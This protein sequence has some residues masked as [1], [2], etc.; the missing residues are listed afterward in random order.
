M[1]KRVLIALACAIA[2][3]VPLTVFAA[4]SNTDTA[5]AV[6]GFFGVDAS[7]LTDQQK[8]DVAEY[9]QKMADLQKE[10]IN[11]LVE[12]GAMTK[13]QGDAAIKKVD[14]MLSK[15]GAAGLFPFAGYKWWD[16]K[17]KQ[18]IG[19]DTSKLTDQQKADLNDSINRMADLL[20]EI[21]DKMVANGT[22]TKEQGDAAI[23]GVDNSAKNLQEKG[24][25]RG[26][27]M[28]MGRFHLPGIKGIDASKLTTQQKSDLEDSFQR[29]A[30]LQKEIVNK[31]V[32]NGTITKEQGQ[33]AVNRIDNL[34]KNFNVDSF[35]KSMGTKKG[36]Q[37]AREDGDNAQ[38]SSS[39]ASVQ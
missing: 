28:I 14:D 30:A 29:V 13:E 10:F 36:H 16:A 4:T 7:K 11:K 21:I 15:G 23:N 34:S 25:S 35:L 2:L 12:D 31:M 20:K 18:A 39:T 3:A 33:A 24:L 37:D 5:K 22:I 8:A 1:K 26:I 6:R 17:E 27:G 32:A 19:I 9:S 38:T